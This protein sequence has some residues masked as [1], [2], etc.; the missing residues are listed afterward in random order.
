MLT[1]DGR[2]GPDPRQLRHRRLPGGRTRRQWAS[3]RR[4]CRPPC[5]RHDG[6]AA[7]DDEQERRPIDLGDEAASGALA[8][9]GA[10]QVTAERRDQADRSPTDES[11]ADESAADE[12]APRK[13]AVWD[14]G[15]IDQAA[16]R[17]RIEETRTRLKVKAFD[18]MIRG[19]VA[20]LGRDGG[21]APGP[22]AEEPALDGDLDG[23]VDGAFSEQEY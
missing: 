4:R 21:E 3:R 15:A 2:E 7:T 6:D 22:A 12:P 16:M 19:Q 5:V 13:V 18:A 10:P 1:S 8:A 11:S 20:L 9:A 23:M 14:D 17:S